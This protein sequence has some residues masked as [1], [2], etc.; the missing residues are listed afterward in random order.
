MLGTPKPLQILLIATFLFTSPAWAQGQAAAPANPPSQQPQF[1]PGFGDITAATVAFIT[2]PYK[3][4]DSVKAIKGTC[5]LV[6]LP[7]DRLGKDRVWTYLVTNRHVATAEGVPSDELLPEVILRV[8]LSQPQDGRTAIDDH[9]P[10]NSARRWFYPADPTVDLAVLPIGFDSTKLDL[11][12]IPASMLATD[13]VLKAQSV[14]LGDPVFFVGYFAQFPGTQRAQPIY[15]SGSLAM[16]PADPIQMDG[17]GSEH[18][19]LADVHA[20]LGNS[21]SPLFINLVGF[22]RGIIVGGGP[23]SEY[24][25]GVV[26]GFIPERN[27]RVTG[28]ATFEGVQGTEPNSGIL[29]FVPAQELKDL[30]DSPE[31]Q[32]QRNDEVEKLNH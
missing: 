30:L 24:L 21:G 15:R 23:A 7:D 1:G 14:G 18:L 3:E 10:L 31:L 13:D 22:R 25:L 29:T 26:N 2:V 6:S 20:F 5:F 9:V 11:K 32:K 4:G 27:G 8:N 17:G 19:Y 12:G 28:A 16:M